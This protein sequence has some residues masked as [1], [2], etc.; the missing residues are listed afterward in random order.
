MMDRMDSLRHDPSSI[1]HHP[2]SIIHHPIDERPQHPLRTRLHIPPFDPAV[3]GEHHVQ[4]HQSVHRG[5][6]DLRDPVGVAEVAVE[7]AAQDQVDLERMDVQIS[8]QFEG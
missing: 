6:V 4:R 8:A 2:S 1:I 5:P 3:L 7:P